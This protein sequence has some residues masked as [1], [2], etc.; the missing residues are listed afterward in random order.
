M[1][2]FEG[3]IVETYPGTVFGVEVSRKN[4][5]APLMVKCSLKSL[6][7]KKRVRIIKGDKVRVEIN[8]EDMGNGETLKGI[9]VERL[10]IFVPNPTT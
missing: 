5:L 6:L 10:P 8:P 3:K 1:I 7:I 9:I 2:Y 4:D